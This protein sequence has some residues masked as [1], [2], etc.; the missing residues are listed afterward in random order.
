MAVDDNR[1]IKLRMTPEMKRL[2]VKEL[3]E[4]KKTRERVRKKIDMGTLSEIP[5]EIEEAMSL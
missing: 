4:A 1:K 5:K 2:L 3:D